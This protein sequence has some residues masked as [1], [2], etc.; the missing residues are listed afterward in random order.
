MIRCLA[1]LLVFFLVGCAS[2]PTKKNS[3]RQTQLEET[4]DTREDHSW[5]QTARGS[6]R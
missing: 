2:N 3:Q 1:M 4:Q 5:H 6:F